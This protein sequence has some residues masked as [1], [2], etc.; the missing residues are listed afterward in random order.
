MMI[1]KKG[2]K[3]QTKTTQIKKV[4]ISI[5]I[6]MMKE[7]MKERV[8]TMKE[9]ERNQQRI[10]RMKK[11]TIMILRIKG[12]K[13]RDAKKKVKKENKKKITKHFLKIKKN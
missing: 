12:N 4:E 13:K 11:K 3:Q 7:I 10:I 6:Q 9:K 1:K 8:N 5:D 2:K